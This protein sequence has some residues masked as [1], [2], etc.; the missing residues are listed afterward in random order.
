[1][2]SA[3]RQLLRRVKLSACQASR[4]P[5]TALRTRARRI[6]AN[7]VIAAKGA[8]NV[9][10]FPTWDATAAQPVGL[11]QANLRIL[12]DPCRRPMH[13][14]GRALQVQFEL[15]PLPVGVHRVGAQAEILRDLA[16]GRPLPQQAKHFQL[17]IG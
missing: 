6:V 3:L 13:Q 10:L 14:F 16:G 9:Q 5:L 15:Q 2:S 17:S 7:T 11:S 12:Q 1:M 4:C 8:V